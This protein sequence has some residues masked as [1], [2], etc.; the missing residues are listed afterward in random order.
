MYKKGKIFIVNGCITD[1]NV[2]SIVV[3]AFEDLKLTNERLEQIICEK[4]GEYIL[5]I[6]KKLGKNPQVGKPNSVYL[7]NGKKNFGKNIIFC[8][9]FEHYS[10][11]GLYSTE[12]YHIPKTIKNVLELAKKYNLKSIAFSP[13][14]TYFGASLEGSVK[15]MTKAFN[16]HLKGET[17]VNKISLVLFYRDAYKRTLQYLKQK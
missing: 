8:V 10:G 1:Y 14:G 6:A 2:D 4:G 11:V 12:R 17:S 15:V 9:P 5:Q 3:S 16:E 13:L 7:I